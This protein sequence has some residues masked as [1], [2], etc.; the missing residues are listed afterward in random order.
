MAQGH[1]GVVFCHREGGREGKERRR[2]WRGVEGRGEEN[3][4]EW[5]RK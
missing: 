3:W 4:R 1:C 5:T 2:V